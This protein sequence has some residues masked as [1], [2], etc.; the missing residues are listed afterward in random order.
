MD[1]CNQ[2]IHSFI[3]NS[4]KTFTAYFKH[5]SGKQVQ[6]PFSLHALTI[7]LFSKILLFTDA[8]LVPPVRI[9]IKSNGKYLL[10]N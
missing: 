9:F 1:S 6:I 10:F 2:Y 5:K 3:N 7:S 4:S 8:V